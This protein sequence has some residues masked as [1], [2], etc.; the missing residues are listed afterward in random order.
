MFVGFDAD[1]N[2]V[3]MEMIDDEPTD[4]A[5]Y[6]WLREHAKEIVFKDKDGIAHFYGSS[7]DEAEELDNAID[8]AMK[9][10]A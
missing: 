8:E 1:G 4:A 7:Y 5:R 6:R 9:S 10:S 3:A 2:H